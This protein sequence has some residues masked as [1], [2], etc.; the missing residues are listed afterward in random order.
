M[1]I[2]INGEKVLMA[3]FNR[4]MPHIIRNMDMF[5]HR[6]TIILTI[7]H[8]ETGSK[9]STALAIIDDFM[10]KIPTDRNMHPNR[11]SK[12]KMYFIVLS[13]DTLWE[14]WL[15]ITHLSGKYGYYPSLGLFS[16][17]EQRNKRVP[18]FDT[19]RRCSRVICP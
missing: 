1:S 6:G 17:G 19:Q 14:G 18:Q 9:Y 3:A 2:V 13:D 12:Y 10:H 15:Y 11:D 7:D 8:R 16:K 5:N 4:S